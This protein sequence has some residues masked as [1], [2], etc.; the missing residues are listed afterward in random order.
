MLIGYGNTL[1]KKSVGLISHTR[2]KMS[3][4][5]SSMNQP[6]ASTFSRSGGLQNVISLHKNTPRRYLKHKGCCICAGPKSRALPDGVFVISPK[7]MSLGVCKKD[8]EAMMAMKERG[9]TVCVVESKVMKWVK[10]P[11]GLVDPVTNTWE[12]K[13]LH[14]LLQGPYIEVEWLD[15]K[16]TV[17]PM[18]NFNES[19]PLQKLISQTRARSRTLPS[20]LYRV[21]AVRGGEEAAS[22][23]LLDPQPYIEVKI[24]AFDKNKDPNTIMKKVTTPE[25]LLEY[26]RFA[27]SEEEESG[28]EEIDDEPRAK[29]RR[30]D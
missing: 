9:Y 18:A 27:D 15:G 16:R 13:Q 28:S 19:E 1:Q 17:E 29:R 7:R 20:S 6:V 30:E 3:T 21:P 14:A 24:G 11:P 5:S 23:S 8:G 12:Y 22:W 4:P 2:K 25:N 26:L 10:P